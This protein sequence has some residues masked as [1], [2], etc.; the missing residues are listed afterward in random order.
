MKK[1]V[2][3]NRKEKTANILLL[4]IF[5]YAKSDFILFDFTMKSLPIIV[6]HFCCRMLEDSISFQLSIL[7]SLKRKKWKFR[8]RKKNWSAKC[9]SMTL[10]ALIFKSSIYVIKNGKSKIRK[11]KL[12]FLIYSPFTLISTL[13]FHFHQLHFKNKILSQIANMYDG[14]RHKIT[15]RL[16]KK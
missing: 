7:E 9:Q 4:N 8:S 10:L 3:I 6:F 11:Q 13:V 12:W 2:T 14:Y 1:Y 16:F 15:K 5:L